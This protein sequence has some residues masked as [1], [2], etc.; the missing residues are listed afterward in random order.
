MF[1]SSLRD[2][3]TVAIVV[4]LSDRYF[5]WFPAAMLV[6]IRMGTN[7]ASQYKSL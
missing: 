5:Y 7:L 3:F 1:L 2:K 6:P 4:K